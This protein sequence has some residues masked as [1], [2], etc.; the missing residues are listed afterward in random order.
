[1]MMSLPYRNEA[2]R[3][4]IEFAVSSE[5]AH[6]EVWMAIVEKM[7]QMHNS[8]RWRQKLIGVHK[9][10]ERFPS[11]FFIP[12]SI[13]P[14]WKTL[15][16][17]NPP[18]IVP[19]STGQH[20]QLPPPEAVT[21]KGLQNKAKALVYQLIR[22]SGRTLPDCLRDKIERKL[23]EFAESSEEAR[24][25]LRLTMMKEMVRLH[26]M[27]RWQRK[28]IDVHKF[29]ERFPSI[30]FP[31]SPSPGQH[32][33]PPEAVMGNHIQR[34]G[35]ALVQQ[36]IHFSGPNIDKWFSHYRDEAQRRLIE[37]A[38]SSEGARR[39]VR[40]I[41]VEEMV[42]MHSGKRRPKL[43]GI[44]RFI[45]SCQSVKW[46][47]RKSHYKKNKTPTNHGTHKD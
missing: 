22:F 25:E 26:N 33:Q 11:I 42:L 20:A 45:E 47:D 34:K 29:I 1:M 46:S 24:R 15:N 3:K 19:P 31:F 37:F 35:K 43:I 6:R 18:L 36:L 13:H 32:D 2:E 7:V 14:V 40:L 12:E 9:F 39:E 41:M 28:L 23:V 16:P 44:H 5:E 30:F 21:A 8:K 27:K 17:E 38:E 4:L 10:I